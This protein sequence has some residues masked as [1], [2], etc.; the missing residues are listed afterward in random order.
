LKAGPKTPAFITGYS[1]NSSNSG[2]RNEWFKTLLDRAR[3]DYEDYYTRKSQ[4]SGSSTVA[5]MKHLCGTVVLG[6]MK[7]L[8]FVNVWGEDSWL[9]DAFLAVRSLHR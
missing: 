8:D 4:D 3:L 1:L 9:E 2:Q 6:Y 7:H 5:K